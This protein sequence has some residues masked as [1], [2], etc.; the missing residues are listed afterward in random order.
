MRRTVGRGLEV[1]GGRIVCEYVITDIEFALY[2]DRILH[3]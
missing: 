2:I 1:N 3:R